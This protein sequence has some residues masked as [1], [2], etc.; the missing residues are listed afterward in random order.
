VWGGARRSEEERGY[1]GT[2]E[3]EVSKCEVKV[4]YIPMYVL[5][6]Y[7]AQQY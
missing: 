3:G 6:Y 7:G 5:V 1:E 2:L 4:I